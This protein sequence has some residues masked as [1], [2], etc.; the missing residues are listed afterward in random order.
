MYFPTVYTVGGKK[1]SQPRI[2]VAFVWWNKTHIAYYLLAKK[3]V[4]ERKL[5]AN[6]PIVYETWAN[7]YSPAADEAREKTE[8]NTKRNETTLGKKN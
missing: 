1:T 5:R 7:N 3:L 2:T 6:I 4:A 8:T